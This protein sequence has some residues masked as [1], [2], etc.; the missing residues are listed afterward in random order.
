M[1]KLGYQHNDGGRQ[2]ASFKGHTSDCVCR[3]IAIAVDKPYRQVYDELNQLCKQ[4]KKARSNGSCA[5]EGVPRRI[6]HDFLLRCGFTWTP[7]MFIGQGCR[8]HARA[9]EL[10]EGRLVLRLSKHLA[11]VIDRVLHDNHDCTR[12]GT[13]CVYGY[14]KFV[15][16]IEPNMSEV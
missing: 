7:T 1:I 8:V 5:R 9:D 10:P 14:Y 6:Y 16:Q 15:K 2:E 4:D 13:R 3:A 11:A 12:N